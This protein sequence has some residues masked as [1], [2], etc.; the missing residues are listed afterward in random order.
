MEIISVY[1]AIQ[2]MKELT[3]KGKSFTFSHAT[4]NRE[5]HSSDGIRFVK[6]A[7]LRPKTANDGIVNSDFKLFYY[8]EDQQLPR[9]CWQPL[10]MTFNGKKVELT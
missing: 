7:K 10:I 8:D 2:E 1:Q 3:K 6:S 5:K 9:N 4:L